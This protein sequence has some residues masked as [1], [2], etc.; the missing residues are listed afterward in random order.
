MEVITTSRGGKK[1]C[2][3]GFTYTKKLQETSKIRWECSK[4]KALSCKGT[5]T[6]DL[7][8]TQVTVITEHNHDADTHGVEVEKIKSQIREKSKSTLEKPMQIV[9][10]FIRTAPDT[11]KIRMGNISALKRNVRRVRRGALPKEPAS[12]RELE[13][14]EEWKTVGGDSDEQFIIHDSGSDFSNHR[15][16]VFA[17]DETLRQL[18]S[19]DTWYMD[20]NFAMA[21]KVF[22]QLYVIR[23]PLGDTA[24]SCAYAL[25]SHKT[26]DCYEEMLQAI[27]DRCET[28]GFTPDPT[29]V[30]TDFELATIQA[31]N[32]I[33]GHHVSTQGCFF[34][35]TQSTWRKI[36]QL[37]LTDRYKT[38]DTVKSF[39]GKLDALA[40]LPLHKVQLGM[41]Q[42]RNNTP[43][44]L[45]ELVAYFDATYVTGSF[46]V[47]Q[48][49]A[50]MNGVVPPVRVRRRP[51][52]F[53]PHIWNVYEI[54]LAG[55]SRTNNLC[56]S[57]NLAFSQL[58][59]HAHP[60]I[61]T[62]IACLRK[63][64]AL[65]L[66]AIMQHAIGQLPRKRVKRSTRNLQD[67]LQR[68]CSEH[69]D[70]R[71]TIEETLNAVSHSIRFT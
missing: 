53:P 59:G 19:A 43:D 44:G 39:C 16:I 23:V 37:G 42:I 71:R 54:T 70:D 50:V 17:A 5:A 40:F 49:S 28:L 11:V 12:L 2:N 7:G 65:V 35:L 22:Q 46:H 20:G 36:Q 48:R 67:I 14:P 13:I 30:V 41:E 3:L 57:W 4:R 8:I 32:S 26:R 18:G 45:E 69:R 68:I 9:A 10:E 47:V 21:P 64:L 33:L 51:P 24:V 31:T 27:L 1:L 15:V 38:D 34:H 25:L 60:S 52:I 6:T 56:E 55:E 29:T 62:L 66:T 58:V 61:W 63:D